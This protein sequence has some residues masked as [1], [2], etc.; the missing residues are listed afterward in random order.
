MLVALALAR[1]TGAVTQPQFVDV[2]AVAGVTFRHQIGATGEKYISETMGAGLAAFDS[3][4]DGRQDLY[5]VNSAGPAG[6]YRNGGDWR[7]EDQTDTAGV[8]NSGYGL[9]SVAADYDNDGDADIFV[10]AFGPNLLYRND[11]TGRFRDIAPELGLDD[12]SMATGATFGDVDADGDLD[13]FVANYCDFSVE[14]NKICRRDT[15][16]VYCAPD[17]YPAAPDLFY[18][19]LGDGRFAEV[20]AEMGLLPR[21]AREIGAVFTDLDGDGDADLYVAGDRT[22]NLLYMN[23]GGRF[24]ESGLL[25]GT[26]YSSDG[27]PEAGMGIAVG[28]YDNDDRLDLF[29]TNFLWES[30]TLYHNEGQ[31]YFTDATTV[32]GLAMPSRP[33][34]GWGTAFMDYDNDGDEDLFVANSHLDDNVGLFD[35]RSTYAQINQ[36][37]RNEGGRFVEVTAASGPG[38]ALQQVSRGLA[39]ADYDDDGDLDVAINNSGQQ[40]ALLR[41]DG[42]SQAGHWLAVKAVGHIS[43][44]DAVGAKV[45]VRT[46]QRRQLR[47]IRSGGSYL[48]QH[49]LRV[50]FGVGAAAIIDEV[51]VRWPSGAVQKLTQ[52]A[53][54][55]TIVVPEPVPGTR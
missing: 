10:A 15:F 14:T 13:L 46:G 5:F 3:D 20:G 48:S 19:N 31:A 41:N 35:P 36:L 28:D 43:N 51:E 55:Q 44:R 39:V 42:G 26:A 33:M 53:V 6:L 17:A 8:G 50:F 2:A 29:V 9:G 45:R 25:V 49:D 54:D 7:L 52:V 30:N 23:E 34:M 4:G 40:A 32:A 38:L 16:P 21:V 24:S 37:F 1:A 27:K 12:A 11:G 18:R 47:E 22:A